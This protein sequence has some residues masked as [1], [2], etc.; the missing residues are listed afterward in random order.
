MRPR[1]LV[2]ALAGLPRA[3]KRQIVGTRRRLSGESWLRY[4]AS[5]GDLIEAFGVDEVSGRQH[6][7]QYGMLDG[8]DPYLF[9]ELMYLSKYPDLRAAF[10]TD[11]RAA[12][13]HFIQYGYFEER[14]DKPL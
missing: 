10:G 5:Y 13:T 12:A 7:R 4:I 2:R 8:R 9:N 11:A 3:A 14:T 1:G 6:Y